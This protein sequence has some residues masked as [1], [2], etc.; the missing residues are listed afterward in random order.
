MDIKTFIQDWLSAANAYDAK[1]FI[2]KW[3][4]DATL[5]DSSVGELLKGHSGIRRYFEDYFIGYNTQ[6]RLVQLDIIN[7]NK[8]QIEVEFT[9]NFP[10]NT[11]G[12][13]FDFTFKGGKILFVKAELI[14]QVR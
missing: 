9:G 5:D 10:G 1:G 14:G 3:R 13:I 11:I 8:A 12:G 4:K 7:D 6:T 2:E